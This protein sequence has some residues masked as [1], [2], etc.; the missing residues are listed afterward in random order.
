MDAVKHITPKPRQLYAAMMVGLDH[1]VG[2][3]VLALQD[4][5]MLQDTLIVFTSDNGGAASGNYMSQGSNW[6]L[7]GVKGSA[8]EGGVRAPAFM[9]HPGSLPD[10]G[11]VSDVL[12]HGICF[13]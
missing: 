6:P 3:V 13:Y 8:W 12:M 4:S 7:R 11:T 9:W 1:S 5:G 10:S 2:Q